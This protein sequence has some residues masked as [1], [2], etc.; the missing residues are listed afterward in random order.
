MSPFDDI[1]NKMSSSV[2]VSSTGDIESH[3]RTSGRL[4]KIVFFAIAAVV[5][6]AN[7]ILPESGLYTHFSIARSAEKHLTCESEN[8]TSISPS[9]IAAPLDLLFLA[10][11]KLFRNTTSEFVSVALEKLE[12]PSSA[13]TPSIFDCAQHRICFL[14]WETAAYVRVKVGLLTLAGAQENWVEA[15]IAY[16]DII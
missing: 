7:T 13:S 12:I 3:R 9:N 1:V 14:G 15:G 6:V 4:L 2:S 16:D 11:A 5:V 10:L 8:T